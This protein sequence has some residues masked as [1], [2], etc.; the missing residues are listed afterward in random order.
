VS[1]IWTACACL[2]ALAV[3]PVR[4]QHTRQY[5]FTLAGGWVRFDP[6]LQL[7]SRPIGIV[8]L[9]YMFNAHFGLEGDIGLTDTKSTGFPGVTMQPLIGGGSL[10][11]NVLNSDRNI[12]YVLGGYS[13]QDYGAQNPYRFTDGAAHAALG[14]RIFLSGSTALRL[15]A[16]GYMTPTTRATF[17]TRRKIIQQNDI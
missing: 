17:P 7:T 14:D 16:R 9:G 13:R 8:R 2:L 15:E 4:A 11:V 3:A 5:E 12:L 1:R 6:K 10:V